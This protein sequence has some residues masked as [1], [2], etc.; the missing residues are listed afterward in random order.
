MLETLGEQPLDA[1]LPFPDGHLQ[2][3]EGGVFCELGE[4][5]EYATLDE[6]DALVRAAAKSAGAFS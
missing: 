1:L 2:L 5:I 6:L 3:W 4:S